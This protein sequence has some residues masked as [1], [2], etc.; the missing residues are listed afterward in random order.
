MAVSKFWFERI[1]MNWTEFKLSNLG[2][3]VNCSI[4]YATAFGWIKLS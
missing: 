4:N 2:P 3:L 1:K